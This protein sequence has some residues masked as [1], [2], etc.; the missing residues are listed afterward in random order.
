VRHALEDATLIQTLIDK[1]ER[2]ILVAG[3]LFRGMAGADALARFAEAQRIPLAVTWK[4]QDCF[5]KSS[6]RNAGPL[7]VG[8]PPALRQMLN[9]ADLVIA[10]GTRLGDIATLN[11]HFPRAPVPLQ[12]LVHIYP[13]A[14]PIGKVIRPEHGIIADPVALIAALAQHPRVVSSGREAWITGING[15]ITAFQKFTSPAPEDGV[16]FGEVVTAVAELAPSDA[17]ITTDAG[18]ISTWVHRHWRMTPKNLLLGGIAGA[19]GFGVPAGVAAGLEKP[20]RMAFVF[21]GDGGILMTGQELATAVQ[22][23]ASLKIVLSDNGTYGTI[24]SHQER[25]YPARVSGTDLINPDFTQWA[26]SFGAQAV[27]IVLGDDVRAKVQEAIDHPGPSVIHVKSSAEALSAF[28][29]IS[30]LRD[31]G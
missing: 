18:N 4:N 14:A 19:M 28:S 21:V 2:P 8:N 24:R 5:D 23:G 17:I 30:K 22:Y 11:Y 20:K 3:G 1:A 25:H 16:D 31:K 29:T 26:Q 15:F 10:A 6:P 12:R 13:D 9:E 27:T 7:G